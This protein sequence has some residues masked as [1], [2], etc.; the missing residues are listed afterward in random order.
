MITE[1]LYQVLSFGHKINMVIP[2]PM[3]TPNPRS[4]RL[5]FIERVPLEVIPKLKELAG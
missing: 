1:Q 3:P 5:D 2:H 4:P